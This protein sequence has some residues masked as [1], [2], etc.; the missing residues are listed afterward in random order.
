MKS[1]HKLKHHQP[2]LLFIYTKQ[3]EWENE[4]ILIILISINLNFTRWELCTIQ[5]I[6]GL[7][8]QEITIKTS[9]VSNSHPYPT[10]LI[11]KSLKKGEITCWYVFLLKCLN[12]KRMPLFVSDCPKCPFIRSFTL[13]L[14]IIHHPCLS[15][16]MRL[17]SKNIKTK[18]LRFLQRWVRLVAVALQTLFFL[19]Y[20]SKKSPDRNVPVSRSISASQAWHG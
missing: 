1:Q 11:C 12:A 5:Q 6:N 15:A 20:S 4:N 16:Q 10:S 14:K 2:H 17:D 3:A 19:K 13:F 8:E 9:K 18:E 7:R